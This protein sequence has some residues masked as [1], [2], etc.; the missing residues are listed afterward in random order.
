MCRCL[1]EGVFWRIQGKRTLEGG[2]DRKYKATTCNESL[3]QYSCPLTRTQPPHETQSPFFFFG[4][5]IYAGKCS[6][7]MSSFPVQVLMGGRCALRRARG[8]PAARRRA[9][10]V[11]GKSRTSLSSLNPPAYRPTDPATR[12]WRWPTTPLRR[13]RRHLRPSD[14]RPCQRSTDQATVDPHATRSRPP[15]RSAPNRS[16]TTSSSPPAHQE[17]RLPLLWEVETDRSSTAEEP[18]LTTERT[19]PPCCPVRP[20]SQRRLNGRFDALK[21]LTLPE[22]DDSSDPDRQ[23]SI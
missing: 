1:E 17:G 20:G 21:H 14:C 18:S 5:V 19:T 7:L 22:A 10:F 12:V 11:P 9:R 2:R 6:R 4:E 8:T 3:R 23:A 16:S 15:S 13:R